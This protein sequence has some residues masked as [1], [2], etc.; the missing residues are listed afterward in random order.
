MTALVAGT[1]HARA[2]RVDWRIVAWMA[3]PSVAGAFIGGFF[4]S[5]VP[6]DVLLGLIAA[7]LLYSGLDMLLAL[8][9]APERPGDPR[10]VA[11]RSP[12]PP[13]A[14]SAAPSG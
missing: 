14:S 11:G 4:G 12:V 1:G 3:P 10:L 5:A 2:G 7:V 8:R 9:P 6:E 13:S